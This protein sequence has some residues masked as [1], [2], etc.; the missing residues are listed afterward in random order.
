[1]S[2]RIL[3]V[4]L[5]A[6]VVIIACGQE[7]TAA[8]TS[9]SR[10]ADADETAAGRQAR[11]KQLKYLMAFGGAGPYSDEAENVK[12]GV[13][14]WRGAEQKHSA[15]ASAYPGPSGASRSTSPTSPVVCVA[16]V[17]GC[18]AGG[19]SRRWLPRYARGGSAGPASPRSDVRS[20]RL[21]GGVRGGGVRNLITA[22]PT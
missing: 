22:N 3:A 19:N 15:H 20:R 7:P 10:K 18:L 8:P 1:M 16:S 13:K 4:L 12:G 6:L 14:P 11:I 9:A 5:L 2:K 21:G 17:A